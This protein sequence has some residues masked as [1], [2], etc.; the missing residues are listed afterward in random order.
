MV[1]DLEWDPDSGELLAVGW[2]KWGGHAVACGPESVPAS[3]WR[4]IEDPEIPLVE[5]TTADAK[6]LTEYGHAPAGPIV[7][8]QVAAWVL[9]EN[10]KLSLEAIARRYLKLTMDKRL[11]TAG[12]Y[13]RT[14]EGERVPISEA[15]KKQLYAYCMRDVEAEGDLLLELERRLAKSGMLDYFW[16]EEVPFTGLL[17]DMD[18][19][20]LPIDLR[21]SELLRRKLER[22]HAKFVESLTDGLPAAFNLGSDLQ[23]AD[24]LFTKRAKIPG[25]IPVGTKQKGFVVT[26]KGRLWNQGYWILRGRG[27]RAGM[28]TDTGK[29]STSKTA[30]R[31]NPYTTG[32]PWVVKYLDYQRIDKLLTTYLRKFPK[33]AKWDNH[34]L[35]FRVYSTFKQTG[36]VTGRL[37]SSDINLQNIPSRG[38][39]GKKVRALFVADEGYPFILG[40][41]SQLE[42][43]LMAHFSG[44]PELVR[45][46]REKRDPFIE[47]AT[48]IYGR[49]IGKEDDERAVT[50]N[51]WYAQGYGATALKVSEMLTMEGFP[52][53]IDRSEELLQELKGVLPVYFDW[54]EDLIEDARAR[55]YVETIGGRRRR[56]GSALR[57]ASWKVA[58][59]GER[60]AANAKVQGSAADIVRRA[61]LAFRYEALRLCAQV[62]DELIYQFRR[63]PIDTEVPY[64]LELLKDVAER[65]HGFDLEVP[66]VFEPKLAL[67]WAD[68]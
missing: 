17:V 66:V 65:G 61:M 25:R 29:P 46:F 36:T 1:A 34:L 31:M 52:T 59:H 18:L 19:A 3:V 45:I 5:F 6:K 57:G 51:V 16:R 37:S 24:Y 7:D 32:D 48:K 2:R 11:D 42:T 20:G 54:R 38:E 4:M 50:K 39:M 41:Y 47:L 40:D 68:K 10:Q 9:N 63:R 64:V 56:V 43:R 44:D 22:Q 12:R 49:P 14:D 67:S 60:A 62:H 8:L 30:L 13:F 35:G 23:V 26:K 53:M 21:R 28:K 55:G 15:P 58:A 33:I 27:L